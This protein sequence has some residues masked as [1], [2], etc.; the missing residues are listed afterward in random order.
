MHCCDAGVGSVDQ[1]L[2]A[3]EALACG[4]HGALLNAEAQG[5]EAAFGT[6]GKVE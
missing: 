1:E 4:R 6:R 5:A 3:S 2:N